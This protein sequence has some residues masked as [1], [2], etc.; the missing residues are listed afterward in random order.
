MQGSIVNKGAITVIAG[1]GYN[2]SVLQLQANTTLT[3]GGT[4]TLSSDGTATAFIQQAT[5]GLTLTNAD[6][7][8]QGYGT[9]GNGGLTLAN[10]GTINANVSGQTL[11][12][13]G[14]GG[15]N[16]TGTLEATTEAPCSSAG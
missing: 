10:A 14:T 11:T 9:I 12:L 5:N 4:V 7:T 2:N 6:N 15:V 1:N 16:N 8:I 3:G 13:N